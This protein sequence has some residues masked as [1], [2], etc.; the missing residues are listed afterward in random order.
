MPQKRKTSAKAITVEVD[1]G[2]CRGRRPSDE[3]IIQRQDAA[4]WLRL[5]G[6]TP[7]EV[8]EKMGIAPRTARDYIQRARERM[9]KELRTLDGRAGVLHQFSLL[10]YVVK[11]SLEAWEQSKEQIGDGRHLDRIV[12][13]SR[14]IRDLL[15]LDPPEV[16][17]LLMTDDPMV[18]TDEGLRNFTSAELFARYC[19]AVKLGAGPG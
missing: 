14:E 7:E 13:T 1:P 4:Y 18:E 15:G 17:R 16:K 11:E 3:Q 12:S 19:E 6:L 9:V 2:L 8:A 5:L 10:N